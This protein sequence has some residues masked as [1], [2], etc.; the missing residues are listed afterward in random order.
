MSNSQHLVRLYRA[1]PQQPYQTSRL[2]FRCYESRLL[3]PSP[4]RQT[5]AGS[6]T[7]IFSCIK[8]LLFS[9]RGSV[10][11]AQ[12]HGCSCGLHGFKPDM[13]SSNPIW[14]LI[15][16]IISN[17]FSVP[18]RTS[19]SLSGVTTIAWYKGIT[20]ALAPSVSNSPA[21]T[22]RQMQ[23]LSDTA[24]EGTQFGFGN[25]DGTDRTTSVSLTPTCNGSHIRAVPL[26]L[27]FLLARPC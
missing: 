17:Q 20:P 18:G 6:T 4:A 24:Y 7:G 14:S 2:R 13:Q 11:H 21:D 5:R 16:I 15:C 3:P 19:L 23:K 22:R 9:E 1:N 8:R 25:Q 10:T 12:R 27:G 26:L